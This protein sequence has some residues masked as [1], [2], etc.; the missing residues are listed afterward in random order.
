MPGG[1]RG[2]HSR[3]AGSAFIGWDVSHLGSHPLGN[4]NPCPRLAPHPQG[5]RFP[6]RDPC[7]VRRGRARGVFGF[8]QDNALPSTPG[9]THTSKGLCSGTERKTTHSHLP[10]SDTDHC[11]VL[12]GFAM[13]GEHTLQRAIDA[14]G[15]HIAEA[16][17]DHTGQRGP[18]RGN[19]F[20]KAEVVDQHNTSLL[21]SLLNNAWVW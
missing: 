10:L 4:H 11:T 2:C 13:L 20:P 12:Q 21:A 3:A 1:A 18:T 16:K 19:Q 6:W 5:S 17:R 14:V 15:M 9:E 8:F 7:L